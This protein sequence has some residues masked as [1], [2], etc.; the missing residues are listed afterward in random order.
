MAKICHSP[1]IQNILSSGFMHPLFKDVVN[2]MMNSGVV[3]SHHRESHCNSLR[4]LLS[5]LSVVINIR[6]QFWYPIFVKI[7]FA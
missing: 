3:N 1:C 7:G 2:N 6:T 4:V 5:L